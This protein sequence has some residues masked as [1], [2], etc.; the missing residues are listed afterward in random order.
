MMKF[1]MLG[2]PFQK[3]WHVYEPVYVKGSATALS[4]KTYPFT[5]SNHDVDG[6]HTWF[7]QRDQIRHILHENATLKLELGLA[8][9]VD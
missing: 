1:S 4:L 2:S 3:I 9:F 5:A 6:I 8:T 7:T